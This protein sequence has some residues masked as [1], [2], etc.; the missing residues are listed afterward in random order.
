MWGLGVLLFTLLTG[1]SPHRNNNAQSN[2][3]ASDG[4]DQN[5]N[6]IVNIRSSMERP[7]EFPAHVSKAAQELIGNMLV[8][9]VDDR[10]DTDEI[11]R[12]EW[13]TASPSKMTAVAAAAAAGTSAH[14]SGGSPLKKKPSSSILKALFSK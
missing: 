1:H 8:V 5:D 12:A 13:M 9:R 3:T 4:E 2:A 14:A 7:L 10:I 11:A 6:L